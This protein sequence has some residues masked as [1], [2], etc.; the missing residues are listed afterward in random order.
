[1]YNLV[2]L[3]TFILLG[4]LITIHPQNFIVF[5]NWYSISIKIQLPTTSSLYS[6]P[7]TILFSVSMNLTTWDTS[8]KWESYSICSFVCGLFHLADPLHSWK[9]TCN[10]IVGPLYWWEGLLSS[11][12]TEMEFYSIEMSFLCDEETIIPMFP[13]LQIQSTADC[14]VL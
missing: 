6:L 4:N 1:M 7:G 3:G 9:S 14:I 2:V 13:H 11:T 12:E 10:F 5:P 8:C